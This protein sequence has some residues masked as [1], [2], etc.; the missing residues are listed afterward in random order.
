MLISL[1]ERTLITITLHIR[2]DIAILKASYA[3][4][5]LGLS[6]TNLSL[7]YKEKLSE[8]ERKEKGEI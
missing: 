2:L 4:C 3:R 6:K 5:F 7:A 8:K 1:E